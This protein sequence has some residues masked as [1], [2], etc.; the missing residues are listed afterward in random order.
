MINLTEK[1]RKISC[2][3]NNIYELTSYLTWM[4]VK[5]K[6]GYHTWEHI[7]KHIIEQA[8]LQPKDKL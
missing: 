4:N 5:Y 6:L 3:P 1:I 7:K 8:K 2:K